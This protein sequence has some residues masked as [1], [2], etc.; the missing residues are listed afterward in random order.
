MGGVIRCGRG[1]RGGAILL[2]PANAG[3]VTHEVAAVADPRTGW[4]V[5]LA[6]FVGTWSVGGT[7]AP[8]Q[9]PGVRLVGCSGGGLGACVGAVSC[10]LSCMM[11]F[12]H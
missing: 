7:A 4:A 5:D 12:G 3:V 9:H 6:W 11:I 1:P 2:L 8:M 10:P